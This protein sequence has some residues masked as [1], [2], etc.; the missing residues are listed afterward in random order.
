MAAIEIQD[1]SKR[2]GQSTVVDQLSLQARPGAVTGFLGPNGAGK[3]TTLRM[4]LGLVAPTA[5]RATIGGQPYSQLPEPARS[6]GAVLDSSG[7][8]PGR[9]ARDQLRVLATAARLPTRR[10]EEVLDQVGLADVAERRVK[11]FS[12]G[13]RQ[14]LRIAG[15]LLGEPEVLIL[16]EPA[17]G[18][19]PEG[20]RWLRRL[21]RQIA[22]NGGTVLVSS[23]LL[24][25]IA[26]SVDDVV[27]IARGRLVT[28]SSLSE[29]TAGT[30]PGIRVRTPQPAQM[31]TAL[32]G[33]G[34]AAELIDADLLV[35]FDTTT[36]A[37]GLA[38]AGAGVVIY[39]I[40]AERVDLEQMFLTL[41]AAEGTHR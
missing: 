2:F 18:L 10:V 19:D 26:R 24:A 12:L 41:T 28:A 34:I 13:M 33:Q 30:R 29:L 35:A 23:H 39:E 27:I 36:E 32:A 16:D 6:V 21:L 17:N 4:L 38:A 1:L 40:T 7:F 11:G 31:L 37:V 22:D 15:A 25:E 3:T 9:R 8:H 14:R 20:V 5:G